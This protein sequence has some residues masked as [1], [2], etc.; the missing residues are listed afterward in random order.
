MDGPGQAS[1]IRSNRRA[2]QRDSLY[3]LP[4]EGRGRNH[5]KQKDVS[6]KIHR[7]AEV[8]GRKPMGEES[9]QFTK[10]LDQLSRK[11]LDN[12]EK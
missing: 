2:F 1:G 11:V 12:F 8:K 4:F 6:D 3:S 7:R 5:Q 9:G 10:K